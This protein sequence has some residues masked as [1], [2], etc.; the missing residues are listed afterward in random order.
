MIVARTVTELRE[1]LE[2]VR[3]RRESV[4]LVPTMGALHEGHLSLVDR[5]V[6]A[7]DTSVVSIFVNPMQFS[8]GEDLD[9]Y[10]RSLEADCDL[11]REHGAQIV[12]APSVGEIYPDG[13]PRI[14][15]DPGPLARRY[16]GA[17][18]PGHFR[19]VLTVVAKLLNL[20]RPDQAV[21]GRKDL[22][23]SVLVRRMV[24]D[25]AIPVDIDIAPI[26]READGLALSSRNRYLDV[27]E[28]EQAVGLVRG[29]ESA[30]RAYREGE[31]SADSL[32]TAVREE[33]GA[34]PL[35]ELEYVDVVGASDLDRTDPVPPGCAVIVAARCGSTRL[36]DNMLLSEDTT[37]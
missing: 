10:P 30:R 32:R 19:G 5:C 33:V 16:C 9:R 1:A 37:A 3:E 26:V 6:E 2:P 31:R 21:F 20:V 15:V 14:S 17:S 23:Q 13:A 4:G 29:L 18:R 28:R 27:S 25:F 24:A 11:A 35:L 34:R 36:I 7:V 22:Q 12:F 8:P